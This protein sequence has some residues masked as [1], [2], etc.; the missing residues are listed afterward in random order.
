MK[1]EQFQHLVVDS[2]STAVGKGIL[3][4]AGSTEK[5]VQEGED[6]S[7]VIER[8]TDRAEDIDNATYRYL[9]ELLQL[10][11]DNLRERFPKDTRLLGD[12]FYSAVCVL[13]EHGYSV[14]NPRVSKTESGRQYFCKLSDCGCE[15]CRCRNQSAEKDRTIFNLEDTTKHSESKMLD[16]GL[17]NIVVRSVNLAPGSQNQ[18]KSSDNAN[19]VESV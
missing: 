18:A 7:E 6:V 16:V 5:T 2:G 19:I 1:W 11:G 13:K 14:C 9:V 3:Y 8:M 4:M 17:G 12:V 10:E 15:S